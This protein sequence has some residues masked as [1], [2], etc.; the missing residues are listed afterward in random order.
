[1]YT[2]K[3]ILW[4]LIF[5]FFI[6]SGVWGARI[7]SITMS[8]DISGD[9]LT[10][11]GVTERF[12]T[13]APSVNAVVVMEDVRT[14]TKVK[15]TWVAVDAIEIPNYEI[16]SKEI[17]VPE[18]EARVHFALSRPEGGWPPGNYR[19][20][21]YINGRHVTSVD[22]SIVP[23]SGEGVVQESPGIKE[24]KRSPLKIPRYTEKGIMGRWICND[25]VSPFDVTFES[26]NR[27]VFNG[28]PMEYVLAS[29]V[30]R[31]R[32][33]EGYVDY[34][35][36]LEGNSLV[37]VFPDGF[38]LPCK[39]GTTLSTVPPGGMTTGTPPSSDY[40]APPMETPPPPAR[41]YPG[42]GIG[43]SG[44]EYLLQGMLCHWSGGSEMSS[45]TRVWFDG[46]G[47]FTYSSETAFSG[48]I[49][50]QYG[51]I[52][53]TY[54]GYDQTPTEGGTYRVVGDKVYLTFSDGSTGIATVYMRQADGRITELMYE[55]DLYATGL[56]E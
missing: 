36:T 18:G 47:R 41:G 46:R 11:V 29:G 51:D 4:G 50:D 28:E 44:Q 42:Q 35:Y 31:V 16:A 32:D 15:G 24:G 19:L 23:P 7:V 37:I 48:D 33:E 21:I 49:T 39:R 3:T 12:S 40:P 13:D 22:F 9:D 5:I 30:L 27:L 34:P 56:C 26:R 2:K 1:M 20:L 53:A 14:G 17:D 55:G 10:P 6:P 52:T 43:S 25:G 8:K 38:R 54:G 45:S